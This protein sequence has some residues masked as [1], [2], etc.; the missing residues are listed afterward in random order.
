MRVSPCSRA[1]ARGTKYHIGLYDCTN[2][3]PLQK[4]RRSNPESQESGIR[5]GA[6]D[7][8]R[9]NQPADLRSRSQNLF[10]RAPPDELGATESHEPNLAVSRVLGCA[11]CRPGS[12]GSHQSWCRGDH[13]PTREGRRSSGLADC[14]PASDG[15]TSTTSFGTGTSADCV[16]QPVPK[17]HVGQIPERY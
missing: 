4:N 13:G 12:R 2:L 11:H 9:G 10:S 8:G 6:R 17:L 1:P 14:S 7:G 5:K 3:P 16:S 15:N